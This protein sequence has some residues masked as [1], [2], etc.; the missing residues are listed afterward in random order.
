MAFVNEKISEI[1]K[2]QYDQFQ[3]R[4][5][6]TS[7]EKRLISAYKWTIDRERDTFSVSLEGNGGDPTGSGIP[8]F[9]ALVWKNKAIRSYSHKELFNGLRRRFIQ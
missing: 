3:F 1:D 6:L 9:F 7:Q 2:P 8:V 5:Q 4:S